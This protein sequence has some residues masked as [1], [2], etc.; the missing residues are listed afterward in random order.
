MQLQTFNWKPNLSQNKLLHRAWW[1][2]SIQVW[3]IR[4]TFVMDCSHVTKF[5]P[6]FKFLIS[7]RYSVKHCVN[8]D[9]LNNG[10]NGFITHYWQN[11]GPILKTKKIGL[12]FVTCEQCIRNFNFMFFNLISIQKV[13]RCWWVIITWASSWN[14]T[15][16]E[17]KW[18]G[19]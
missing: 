5:S 17:N 13:R 10:Q 9:G 4:A 2:Q 3:Y 14:G 12:N 18:F 19:G 15:V 1:L 6:I 7:A 16:S 11:N 8:D